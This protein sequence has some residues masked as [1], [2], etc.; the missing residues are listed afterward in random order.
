MTYS[1]LRYKVKYSKYQ[2]TDFQTNMSFEDSSFKP[3]RKSLGDLGEHRLQQII[4]L[5][6]DQVCSHLI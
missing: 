6:P 4:W 3:C 1:K 2:K 5:R